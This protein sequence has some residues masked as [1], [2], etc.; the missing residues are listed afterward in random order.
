MCYTAVSYV[1]GPAIHR[2]VFFKE[3]ELNTT[4]LG[5]VN[6]APFQIDISVAGLATLELLTIKAVSYTADGRQ[7][8]STIAGAVKDLTSTSSTR[9]VSV[10]SSISASTR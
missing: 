7:T 3:L 1:S 4:M 9:T 8:V 5:T 2:V 10:T 6:D